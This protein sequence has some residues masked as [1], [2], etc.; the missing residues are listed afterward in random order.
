MPAG[1]VCCG[2]DPTCFASRWPIAP[3]CAG[4]GAARGLRP[5]RPLGSGGGWRRVGRPTAGGPGRPGGLGRPLAGGPSG[6]DPSR[7]RR[8]GP[9]LGRFALDR[10]PHGGPVAGS[11]WPTVPVGSAGNRPRHDRRL[12]RV[13]AKRPLPRR[14]RGRERVALDRGGHRAVAARVARHPPAGGRLR[15]GRLAAGGIRLP[16]PGAGRAGHA[17][18][19]CR[20]RVCLR[21]RVVA[22]ALRPAAL[23]RRREPGEAPRLPEGG[24]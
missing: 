9:P 18:G 1:G 11:P 15:P 14:R 5:R 4:F 23:G 12:G 6:A 21:L 7:R 19:P 17:A 10:G 13:G 16:G 24:H 2:W 20:G 22:F 8:G 3:G